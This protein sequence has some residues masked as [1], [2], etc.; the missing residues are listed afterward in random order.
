MIPKILTDISV[1]LS[2]QKFSLSKQFDDGRINASI[3]EAEILNVIK[4]KFEIEV[5]RSRAWY[6]FA[7]NTNNDFYPVNIKTTDT[8]HAD[9]LNCKL[10]IYYTLTGLLPDFPNE[11]N[12]LNYF[13]KLKENIGTNENK[14]YYFLVINKNEHKDVFVNS[15]RGLQILQ[16]NGNNLPFQ[17]KWD[18][19]REYNNRTFSEAKEFILSVF[20]QSIKLRAEIYFNFKKYFPEYV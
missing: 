9:N 2:K 8:T 14:D 20:G 18:T 13:E 16:P 4:R 6:D 1:Y 19:N 7:I 10:G 11:T 15:L 3:N 17:C 5:P 12:W